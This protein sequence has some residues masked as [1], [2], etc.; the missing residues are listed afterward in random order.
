M[1]SISNNRLSAVFVILLAGLVAGTLDITAACISAWMQS[2]VT[3]ERVFRY[4]A[5]G[6]LGPPASTGGTSTAALGLFLH[7]VIATGWAVVFYIASRFLRLLT[8]HPIPSGLIYGVVVY[9]LM[10]FVIVPLSYVPARRT[11]PQFQDR[12][13]QA[14]ILMICIG[15]PIALIVRRFGRPNT[16]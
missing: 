2:G 11:P 14:G 5:T 9:L 4:I 6:V 1:S 16:A 10:N 3:P 12:A 15:V 8:E 7:Y 13:L